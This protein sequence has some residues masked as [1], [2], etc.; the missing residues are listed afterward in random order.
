MSR[1]ATL[2]SV[3]V[4]VLV[5]CV[6]GGYVRRDRLRHWALRTLALG[7]PVMLNV[8]LRHG[9]VHLDGTRSGYI[10]GC[11]FIGGAQPLAV[12]DTIR[13]TR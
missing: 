2:G 11:R 1:K 4:G 13:D 5:A 3:G 9:V 12:V 8:E 10:E 6:V 7:S